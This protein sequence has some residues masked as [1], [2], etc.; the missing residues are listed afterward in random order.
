MTLTPEPLLGCRERLAAACL[1]QGPS[2][3]RDSQPILIPSHAHPIPIPSSVLSR[4]LRTSASS[5]ESS[6]GCWATYGWTHWICG[7]SAKEQGNNEGWT[8]MKPLEEQHSL[9]GCSPMSSVHGSSDLL[10]ASGEA[11]EWPSH[12]YWESNSWEGSQVHVATTVPAMS[13]QP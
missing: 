9:C 8:G 13:S 7:Q 12:R 5:K 2:F 4:M 1:Q 3:H 10:R 11:R 6:S